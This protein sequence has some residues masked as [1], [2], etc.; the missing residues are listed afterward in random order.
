ML[1]CS[2][3]DPSLLGAEPTASSGGSSDTE[4]GSTS[5]GSLVNQG[6]SS[7]TGGSVAEGGSATSGG[8]AT[9]GRTE[10]GAASGGVGAAGASSSATGGGAGSDSSGGS[11]GG[12]NGGSAPQGGSAGDGTAGSAGAACAGV[13]NWGLCWYLGPRG[14]SCDATCAAHGGLDAGAEAYVGITAQGGSVT[15]CSELLRLLG[16][17][18][19]TSVASRNDVGLGCHLYDNDPYWLDDPAFATDAHVREAR[20]VCACRQ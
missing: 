15:E 4:G 10:G 5:G 7:S 1:A 16:V 20:I 11:N 19:R 9:A 13:L 17:N 3:Y 8:G 18:A 6:G 12:S 2:V 14:S